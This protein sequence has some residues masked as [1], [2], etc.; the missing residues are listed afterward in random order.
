MQ[1]SPRM[2]TT[3]AESI[4][5]PSYRHR[6]NSIHD[7]LT[8][9]R[10]KK[11]LQSQLLDMQETLN[12]ALNASE[13]HR[14]EVTRLK[15]EIERLDSLLISMVAEKK[16][17]GNKI[18]ELEG[19]IRGQDEEIRN[20]QQRL[21]I[22]EEQRSQTTKLLDDRTAELKGA[23]AFLTTADRYSG[24]DV[25]KMAE[26]LNAEIFQV[27]AQMAEMLVEAPVMED[28]GQQKKII[29]EY[30][31]YLDDGRRIIGSQL[32][33]HLV[34]KSSGIRV[35]PLPL[36]LAF[37]AL[38]TW[39]CVYEGDRFCEGPVGK[40]LKQ[41]YRRIYE[42]ETQAVAGRWR[43]MTSAQ[44]MNLDSPSQAGFVYHII[45]GLMCICGWFRSDISQRV[46]LSI[47]EAVLRV[48]RMWKTLKVAIMQEVTAAEIIIVYVGTGGNY[49]AANMDDMYMD[50][51]GDAV[52]NQDNC[53]KLVLCTIGVGL[54]RGVS[55]RSENGT[56]QIH[57]EV[58]LKPKVA[59]TSALLD[60][61]AD[62]VLSATDG[63][64]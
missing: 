26:C 35:D 52:M 28:C 40:S 41:I 11:S 63:K 61:Q 1:V 6:Q 14:K 44:T 7:F 29:Q 62:I 15:G 31:D 64:D 22:S 51:S 32:F 25:V 27:S 18:C 23:Q 8:L 48:E 56:M 49:D 50:T 54:N 16:E 24:A 33:D 36:Q 20:L 47:E 12:T 9:S 43:V 58:I 53:E 55:K 37:Q 30:K 3:P 59:L 57:R 17:T 39:W 2:E 60:T 21:R 13:A 34:S 19:K 42:S 10:E 5:G 46:T 38:L 45:L 4:Q